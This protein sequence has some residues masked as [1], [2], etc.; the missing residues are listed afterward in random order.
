M[1]NSG[2]FEHIPP[3][4]H[5]FPST[6]IEIQKKNENIWLATRDSTCF[7]YG[8]EVM[9]L[10]QASADM[11][12]YGMN[13]SF[14][15]MWIQWKIKYFPIFSMKI[16][17][18]SKKITGWLNAWHN[19]LFP[20]GI[21]VFEGVFQMFSMKTFFFILLQE[22]TSDL[23]YQLSGGGLGL[24]HLHTVQT[25]AFC[26]LCCYLKMFHCLIGVFT[27]GPVAFSMKNW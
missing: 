16:W 15:S 25:E 3:E 20:L 14:H 8:N 5:F 11:P 10:H 9:W 19:R 12:K 22:S 2:W 26:D 18:F 27:L 24:S 17:I 13:K 23:F 7:L 21:C 6:S 4:Y 1:L